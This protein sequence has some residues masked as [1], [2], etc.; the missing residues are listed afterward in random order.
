MKTVQIKGEA[1][2]N[3]G[4]KYASEERAKGNVPCVLYGGENPV[5]FS[6]PES[7]FKQLLFTPYAYIS[8]I[9]VAGEKYNAVLQDTQFDP[10]SDAL[11]HADFLL[12]P[13]DKPVTVSIP[14]ETEGL[15]PGV[16]A[17]GALQ[18]ILR[19]L[20]VKG[21]ADAIPET[22]TVNV[23]D[24]ELGSSVQV[25]DLSIA[26]GLEVLNAQGAVVVRVQVTRTARMAANSDEETA[27]VAAE[28]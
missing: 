23:S 17:G 4:K 26:D 8:E 12:A 7:S 11:T 13:A 6:A 27:E 25:K 28:A 18:I 22:I 1:R 15:A 5:H 14:V 24:L 3:L 10:V 20:K 16:V 9:E 21:A 2:E 19:K